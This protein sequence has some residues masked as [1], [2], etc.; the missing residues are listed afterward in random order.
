MVITGCYDPGVDALGQI[1]RSLR[2]ETGLVSRAELTAPWS[3]HTTGTPWGVFHAVTRGAGFLVMAD[4][5]PARLEAGDL[6]VIPTG[7]AHTITVSPGAPSR[8]VARLPTV[9]DRSGVPRL[10]HG[11]GGTA[12]ELICG[13][14]ELKLSSAQESLTRLLPDLVHIPGSEAPLARWLEVNLDLLAPE[15]G[16]AVPG[17]AA[18]ATGVTDLLFMRVL[19]TLAARSDGAQGW[20]GALRDARI[21]QALA[22]I[23]AD[24]SQPITAEQLAEGVGMS[25][26]SFYERFRELVGETPARYLTQWRMQ[27]ATDLLERCPELSTAEVAERVGYSS[28]DAFCKSF[29]RTVGVSP[30]AWRGARLAG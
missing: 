27:A 19:R 29:R 30:S 24:P 13:S 16:G 4:R 20:L 9:R 14:F 3:V 11:G 25:K 28:D 17:G 5:P 2:L 15:L 6:V 18:I 8:H 1:L 12:T 21:A 22:R 10:V 23:H 7:A 26:S